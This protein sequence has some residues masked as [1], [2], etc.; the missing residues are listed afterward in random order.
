MIVS[1]PIKSF[2]ILCFLSLSFCCSLHAAETTIQDELAKRG[3]TYELDGD[4]LAI[5]IDQNK[6]LATIPELQ[7]R[8]MLP[9]NITKRDLEKMPITAAIEAVGM[10]FTVVI[11]HTIYDSNPKLDK[12]HVVAYFNP[13]N[14]SIFSRK[15]ECFSFDFDRDKYAKINWDD[16]TTK[17]FMLI[18][19]NF[20]LAQWC[21]Q[22]IDQE[23]R[24]SG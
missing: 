3:I 2:L 14:A 12:L 24:L 20:S 21:A 22:Q 6:A 7:R 19:D 10:S 13:V 5:T 9:K 1:A 11:I 8:G 23:T 18:T 16:I 17:D 15:K 4:Q